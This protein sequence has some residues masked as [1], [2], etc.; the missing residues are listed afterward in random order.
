MHAH[1]LSV[2]TSLGGVLIRRTQALERSA[3]SVYS[4]SLI[5]FMLLNGIDFARSTFKMPIYHYIHLIAVLQCTTFPRM[6][7]KVVPSDCK[8]GKAYFT[9]FSF[10]T[11]QPDCMPC[12]NVS[13][14]NDRACET[15]GPSQTAEDIL[16]CKA[17]CGE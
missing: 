16:N 2:D 11:G 5:V 14:K 8:F 4:I 15:D 12:P 1:L 9:R 3:V 10:M 6:M 13:P 17:N 7:G